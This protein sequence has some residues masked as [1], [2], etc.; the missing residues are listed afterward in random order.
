[1]QKTVEL[2]ASENADVGNDCVK[3]GEIAEGP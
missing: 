2:R 1:M 3:E